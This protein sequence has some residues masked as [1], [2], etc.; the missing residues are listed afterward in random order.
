MYL[1]RLKFSTLLLLVPFF[2]GASILLLTQ[3][4]LGDQVYY[5]RLY[6]ALSRASAE[7]VML[8]A[9]RHVSSAE[10]ISAYL[11]WLGAQLGIEKSQFITLLN[12]IL[13]VG[14]FLLLR[15]RKLRWYA[16]VLIFTNFY[17]IVLMT[18]AE[19]LKIAYIFLVYAALIPGKFGLAFALVSPLAHLQSLILLGG[20]AASKAHKIV[21]TITGSMS[22]KREVLVYVPLLL[23]VLLIIFGFL[24]ESIMMKTEAYM[25]RAGGVVELF[26]VF[27]LA[28]I[29]FLVSK[30]RLRMMLMLIAMAVAIFLIGGARVN[31]IAFTLFA[32]L[33]ILEGRLHHPLV[34]TLLSYFSLKSVL[35]VKNI[36]I[37]GNGF[38][39]WLF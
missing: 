13:L 29:S 22:I 38:G 21:S 31:M 15:K 2:Y 16:H 6:E 28:G 23:L 12:V 26:Q 39:G 9:R 11:L 30:D 7:D 20:L 5:G 25:S 10:P 37:F 19:R 4:T 32:Y 14:I 18:G 33:I 1:V 17:V 36:F 27:L 34:L 35:F 8:L 3:Y 24:Q